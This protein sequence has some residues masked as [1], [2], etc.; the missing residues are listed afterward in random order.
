MKRQETAYQQRSSVISIKTFW[1]AERT[2]VAIFFCYICIHVSAVVFFHITAAM[3]KLDG[4][5]K[6]HVLLSVMQRYISLKS[7]LYSNWYTGKSHWSHD[8]ITLCTELPGMALIHVRVHKS[9]RCLFSSLPSPEP[10]KRRE[11]RSDR[12]MRQWG[13]HILCFINVHFN[14]DWSK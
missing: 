12:T 6:R 5:V 1:F 13:K 2:Y 4:H 10:Y 9:N 3:I 7:V 14:P 8:R 11:V